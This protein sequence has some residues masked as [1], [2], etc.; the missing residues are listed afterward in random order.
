MHL[1]TVDPVLTEHLTRRVALYRRFADELEVQYKE[2]V[3]LM[4]LYERDAQMRHVF[5]DLL[6]DTKEEK[7]AGQFAELFTQAMAN[8]DFQ[9]GV[10][11]IGENHTSQM[12]DMLTEA[13][14]L[15]DD[16]VT[17]A[18]ALSKKYDVVFQP[19]YYDGK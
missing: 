17:V 12:N 15:S 13:K 8:D 5:V 9:R 4:Q 16:E 10:A 6:T 1:E 3:Q 7:L 18:A 14:A 19:N 2:V 11:L